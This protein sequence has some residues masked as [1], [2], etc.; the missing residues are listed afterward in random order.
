PP[1]PPEAEPEPLPKRFDEVRRAIDRIYGGGRQG[2]DPGAAKGL[3]RELEGVLG[4]R[5][6][7]SLTVCRAVFDA[8]LA[9][10]DRRGNTAEHELNWLRLASWGLRPGF[11]FQGDA[12]R[13]EGLW[14]LQGAGLSHANAK[15]NWGEWWVLWRR[16]A[17]GLDAPQQAKLFDATAP[18][19]RPPK[20]PPPP[21]PRAHGHPEMLR[22]LAALERLPAP[23]KVQAA[24]WLDLHFKKVNSW[25]PLGRL[26]ARAPFHGRPDDV[27]APD[28]AAGWLQTLLGLD[29]AQAD[30]ADYAA[31]LIARVT[32]DPQRDVP[33]ELRAQVARRLGEAQASSHWIELVSRATQLDEADAKRI[34]GDA[35]PA[36]LRLS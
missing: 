7:W 22:M 20:G 3:R 9:K 33:A 28:V 36:G 35:L 14:A 23:A 17:A 5:G 19:L 2:H 34:L 11:G 27:V 8:L 1:A 15:A 12:A 10:A 4:P 16:V 6:Q 26:G 32:G 31:V 25:W 21:G 30:G 29:W 24:E 13:V 18:W